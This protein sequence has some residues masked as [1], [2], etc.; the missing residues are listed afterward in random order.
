MSFSIKS[1]ITANTSHDCSKVGEI[2]NIISCNKLN[3]FFSNFSRIEIENSTHFLEKFSRRNSNHNRFGANLAL[4]SVS[5]CLRKPLGNIPGQ[6]HTPVVF[7][8]SVAGVVC[9]RGLFV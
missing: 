2:E 4:G 6:A 3:I 8:V 1:F 5:E 9:V 7:V